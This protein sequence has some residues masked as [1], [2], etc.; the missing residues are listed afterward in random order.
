[1]LPKVPNFFLHISN[2]LLLTCYIQLYNQI[3]LHFL[4]KNSKFWSQWICSWHNEFSV[5]WIYT[6]YLKSVF[7]VVLGIPPVLYLTINPTIRADCSQ[8]VKRMRRYIARGL[9][10]LIKSLIITNRWIHG[11]INQVV[12]TTTAATA[13]RLDVWHNWN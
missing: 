2:F 13:A 9:A 3:F 10:C 1:M 12:P 11:T 5:F 6:E 4:G 8:L 7:C